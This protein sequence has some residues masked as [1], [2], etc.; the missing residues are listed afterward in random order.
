[1]NKEELFSTQ[2]SELKEL[3]SLQ[4]GRISIDDVKEAFHEM[5]L[6]DA[7]IQLILKYLKENT[8]IKI[9]GIEIPVRHHPG[10]GIQKRITRVMCQL[11]RKI[12]NILRYI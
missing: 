12:P 6:D 7:Q 4:N 11:L 1:M 10:N 8:R 5:E 9:D 2:L 3:A